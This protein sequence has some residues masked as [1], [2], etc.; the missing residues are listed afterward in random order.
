MILSDLLVSAWILNTFSEKDQKMYM[1]STYLRMNASKS[2]K[3]SY[4]K[5]DKKASATHCNID[6]NIKN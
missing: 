4:L 5:D 6:H 1:A 3:E 2:K